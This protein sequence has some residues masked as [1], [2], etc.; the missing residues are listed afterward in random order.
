MVVIAQTI[1]TLAS[2]AEGCGFKSI[3]TL[4][5]TSVDSGTPK[6]LQTSICTECKLYIQLLLK[7]T[8]LNSALQIYMLTK[9]SRTVSVQFYPSRGC[10]T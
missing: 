3:P 2:G 10:T 4:F 9:V 7:G 5:E 1:R 6:N 8:E